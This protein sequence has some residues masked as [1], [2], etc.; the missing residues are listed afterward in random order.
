MRLIDGLSCFLALSAGLTVA[1]AKDVS[2]VLNHSA[3]AELNENYELDVRTTDNDG[4]QVR[5]ENLGE[6]EVTF[7]GTYKLTLLKREE[8]ALFY[9]QQVPKGLV[10]WVYFPRVNTITYAKLRA[11]PF[12]GL[13]SSYLMIAK[14]K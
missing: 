11:F 8:N 13:P 5:L 7:N 10:I 4:I 14:C 1:S 12:T 6:D 9:V 3:V 2:C